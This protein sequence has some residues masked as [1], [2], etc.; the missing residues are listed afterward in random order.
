MADG[1]T[2]PAPPALATVPH[3]AVAIVGEPLAFVAAE[4]V[5]G[6]TLPPDTPTVRVEQTGHEIRFYG[7]PCTCGGECCG[8]EFGVYPGTGLLILPTGTVLDELTPQ[9]LP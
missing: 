4:A 3:G 6:D 2:I 7:W 8:P 1:L 9:D 5:W